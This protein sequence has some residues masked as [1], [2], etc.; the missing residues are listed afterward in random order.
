M[1]CVNRDAA[2]RLALEYMALSAMRLSHVTDVT[3]ESWQMRAAPTYA[4]SLTEDDGWDAHGS[5]K[6]QKCAA[7]GAKSPVQVHTLLQ[8]AC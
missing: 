7:N 3:S 5:H 8:Q 1:Q 2:C 6:A 4:E